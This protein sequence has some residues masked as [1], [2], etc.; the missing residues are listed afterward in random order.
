MSV[1]AEKIIKELKSYGINEVK[2]LYYNLS[3][4]E[5]F[6]HEM[7]PKLVGYERGTLTDTGAVSVDTGIFT[8]RSPKDKFIVVHCQTGARG[9]IAYNVLK[10]AGYAVKYL[11]AECKCDPSGNYEIW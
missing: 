11:E 7:D 9:E 8:G 5:L 6:E 1:Q 4:E 2:E 10:D 3:Y